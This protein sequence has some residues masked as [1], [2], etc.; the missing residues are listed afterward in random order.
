MSVLPPEV[1]GDEVLREPHGPPLGARTAN[2]HALP[3]DEVAARLVSDAVAGLTSLQATARLIEVGRN[4]TEQAKRATLLGVLIEGLTEP[5]IL[6]L[7]AAGVLAILL[8]QAR[9]G[10]LILVALVPIVGADVATEYRAEHALEALR[11]ASAPSARVRR[12][13]PVWQ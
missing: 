8:G 6:L 7:A 10:L 5:F 4:E 3:V 1:A 9:D 2:W 11:S 12:D 13:G